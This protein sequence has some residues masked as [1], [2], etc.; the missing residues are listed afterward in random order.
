MAGTPE[1]VHETIEANY[2]GSEF[3]NLCQSPNDLI[4]ETGPITCKHFPKIVQGGSSAK[5]SPRTTARRRSHRN[6]DY[7]VGNGMDGLR[8]SQVVVAKK[9]K[10][11]RLNAGGATRPIQGKC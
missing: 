7:N 4:P 8:R 11:Y 3:L 9:K 2:G 10:A 5:K 6:L 1:P